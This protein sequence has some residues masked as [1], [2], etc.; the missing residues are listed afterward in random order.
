MGRARK[1]SPFPSHYGRTDSMTRKAYG[2]VFIVFVDVSYFWLLRVFYFYFLQNHKTNITRVFYIS[3]KTTKCKYLNFN[4]FDHFS[5]Y[6]PKTP[7]KTKQTKTY[8]CVS[9][10]FF[11][12]WVCILLLFWPPFIYHSHY[13]FAPNQLSSFTSVHYS[14]SDVCSLFDSAIPYI[15]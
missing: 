12:L 7:T 11:Y 10:F 8:S 6:K 5:T 2:L 4:K 15:F 9:L 3:L 1:G 13:T 14:M